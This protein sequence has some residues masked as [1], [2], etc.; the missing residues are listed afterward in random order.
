MESRV[1]F[2]AVYEDFEAEP[3]P[4]RSAKGRFHVRALG[5]SYLA[6]SPT[7]AWREVTA[8]WGADPAA[9]V[10]VEIEVTLKDV[11]DLTD[12]AVHSALG[13]TEAELVATDYDACQKLA[14]R[15][16]PDGPEAIWTYSAADQP[17]GRQLVVFL[18]RLRSG[19]SI[20]IV[21]IRPIGHYIPMP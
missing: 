4:S 5:I 12:P 18:D 17:D 3:I 10:M 16:G 19:S 1:L 20:R 2:R 13:I 9:F 8:R 7:T 15:L 11:L 21:S 14:E 6:G